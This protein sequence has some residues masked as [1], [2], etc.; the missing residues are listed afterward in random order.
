MVKQTIERV[1]RSVG[2]R[3]D[4]APRSTVSGAPGGAIEV[5]NSLR[6]SRETRLSRKRSNTSRQS[7]I[8][9]APNRC[10]SAI[11]G[12]QRNKNP[13]LGGLD[14]VAGIKRWRHHAFQSSGRPTPGAA[15]SR[16]HTRLSRSR[17]R[18]GIVS[19][20]EKGGPVKNFDPESWT[21]Q[22]RLIQLTI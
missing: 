6:A 2:P 4:A 21:I 15:A 5:R 16:V 3:S 12:S 14:E 10:T 17:K 22:P 1:D 11:A 13:K 18:G 20:P 9:S 8:G 19:A 7:C